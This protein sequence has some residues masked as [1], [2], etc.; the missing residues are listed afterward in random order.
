MLKP[1]HKTY[2]SFFKPSS[3]RSLVNSYRSKKYRI[4]IVI[5]KIKQ[6]NLTMGD[7]HF[8]FNKMKESLE[9]CFF[10]TSVNSVREYI[11][12]IEDE[13]DFY[14]DPRFEMPNEENIHPWNARRHWRKKG[15]K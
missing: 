14:I 10:G 8:L 6:E 15:E 1:H 2:Y 3:K 9:I 7:Y 11:K 13:S 12:T 5:N 4:D